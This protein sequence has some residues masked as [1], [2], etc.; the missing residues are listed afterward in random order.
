MRSLCGKPTPA[1]CHLAGNGLV[2]LMAVVCP[3]LTWH[4]CVKA[5]INMPQLAPRIENLI[6][7]LARQWSLQN[8]D[9]VEQIRE[10]RIF[11]FPES[12]YSAHFG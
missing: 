6:V 5:K 10:T 1:E 2:A 4:G 3:K 11:H 7:N 9:I 12:W 8:P